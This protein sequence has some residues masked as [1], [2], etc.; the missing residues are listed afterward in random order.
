MQSLQARVLT[1]TACLATA[2]FWSGPAWPQSVFATLGHTSS[3]QVLGT[4]R[5]GAGHPFTYLLECAASKRS[6]KHANSTIFHCPQ[7]CSSQGVSQSFLFL[8]VC[9][10]VVVAVGG[11][12]GSSCQG[13][14]PTWS[15]SVL[16]TAS[17]NEHGGGRTRIG[18]HPSPAPRA[19]S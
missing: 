2:C 6:A 3:R 18:Y 14:R 8:L 1:R 19:A 4:A 5:F 7:D 15:Q 10:R 12:L 17:L 13:R 16:V 11:A 9:W